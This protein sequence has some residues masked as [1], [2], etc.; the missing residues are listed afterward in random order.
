MLAAGTLA[1][2]LIV[3]PALVAIPDEPRAEVLVEG[4]LYQALAADLDGD[5]PR[6]IVVLT[7]GDGSTIAA[8][9]WRDAPSGWSRIGQP[10]EV[11]PSG[12]VPG[13]A[14]LGS[15]MRLVVRSVDGR[16]RVTLIRQPAYAEDAEGEPGCCLLIDDLRLEGS[17][18]R[19]VPVAPSRTSVDAAWVIDLDGDGTDELV[20][21]TSVPPLGDTSY[22][23]DARVHRW[24]GDRFVIRDTRLAVGSGDTPFPLGDSDGR[25]GDELAII[26]TLGRAAL[27]RVSLGPDDA[28]VTEEAG[29]VA[30]GA[31]AVPLGDERGIALLNLGGTLSVNAWPADEPLEPPLAEV[32][33]EDARILGSVSLAGTESLIVRQARGGDRVHAFGLPAL[34]P[35]RFGAIARSPG[36]AAFGSGPVM[37]FVGSL[38]GGGPDGSAAILSG[39]RYLGPG[40][41][42]DEVRATGLPF[43]ALAGAQ[44]IGLVG[45]DGGQLALLHAPDA[46]LAPIDPRGGRMDPPILH[47]AAAVTVAPLELARRAEAEAAAFDPPADGI[48]PIGA[49]RTVLVGPDGFTVRVDA[50]PGSR[51]YVSAGG[52]FVRPVTTSVGEAGRASVPV[53]PPPDSMPDARFRAL[54]GV[55][56]P[57][58]H[59]YLASWD[60]RV[61]DAAPPLELRAATPFGSS[62]VEVSGQTAEYA[63]VTIAGRSVPVDEDGRFAVRLPAPPWPTEF[64][65]TATDPLGNGASGVVSGVGWFDYRGLPWIGIVALGVSVAAAI[66]YLRV[67]RL[68]PLPR[69]ADDDAGFEELEPD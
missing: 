2:L 16:D 37:P 15:P 58:G 27:Y 45:H 19:L 42:P 26:A 52:P 8:S 56:T 44:P 38:P 18:L 67:P 22:P 1:T 29:P 23:T 35:P 61:L 14:R 59:S 48:I 49:R 41:G 7:N 40:T 50:P 57:A 4:A 60:V 53:V 33:M 64:A 25:P 46:V 31:T 24:S 55:T 20:T 62:D 12:T 5:G 39:G 69:A 11:L 47:S 63:I 28:L 54:L 68:R 17:A 43:A 30:L 21:T 65:A 6:E 32:P 10:L 51:V 3:G 9:A 36:A 34:A 13:V 66:L